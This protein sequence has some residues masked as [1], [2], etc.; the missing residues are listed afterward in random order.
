VAIHELLEFWSKRW[1][2]FESKQV[3]QMKDC[4]CIPHGLAAELSENTEQ[5]KNEIRH[6]DSKIISVLIA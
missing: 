4:L 1:L 3:Y 5:N 6:L 2:A